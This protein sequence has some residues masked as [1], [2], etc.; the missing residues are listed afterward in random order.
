MLVAILA[1]LKAGGAYVPI[2][3]N[4]PEERIEYIFKDSNWFMIITLLFIDYSDDHK[5]IALIR[6][7]NTY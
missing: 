1:V 3:P 6:I 7:K 2:D 4:Y 5:N